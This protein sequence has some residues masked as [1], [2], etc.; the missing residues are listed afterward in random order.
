MNGKPGWQEL[1]EKYKI[2][3]LLVHKSG[4]LAAGARDSGKWRSLA[5]DGK[6]ELFDRIAEAK[7]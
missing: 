5:S 2:N 6:F 1:I 7:P 3:V 4:S